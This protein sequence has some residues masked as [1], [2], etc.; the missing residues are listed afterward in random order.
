MKKYNPSLNNYGEAAQRLDTEIIGLG[1]N[2]LVDKVGN[3]ALETPFQIDLF[4]L[5]DSVLYRLSALGWHVYNICKQHSHVEQIFKA[6]PHDPNMIYA[7]N[8]QFFAFDDF[9]F[10]LVSLYDYYANLV[11]FILIGGQK[12]RIG[13]N[14]LTK[15]SM[16]KKNKFYKLSIAKLIATHEN[17]W[18]KRISDYRA[19]I[20]HYNLIEGNNKL[21]ISWSQGEEVKYNLM[22]SIPEKLTKKL[23]LTSPIHEGIGIDLQFGTLEIAEKSVLWLT[24]LTSKI[25]AEF[26]SNQIKTVQNKKTPTG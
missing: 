14:G 25:T 4:L 18:V 20:I 5:R 16:D 13:W 23:K 11:A 15:S 7:K 26:T 6:N 8:Y 2:V 21:E 22:Y 3:I 10:N 17:E 9:I 19:E 24:E 12:K 1:L